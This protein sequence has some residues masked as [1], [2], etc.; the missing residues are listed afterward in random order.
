MKLTKILLCVAVVAAC[1]KAP[2]TGDT[3]DPTRATEA[4]DVDRSTPLPLDPDVRMGKLDNGLTYYIRRH[5]QPRQRAMLWLAVNAGS[6]LEDDDQKGLAHFVEHMAFNGTARFEK[7]TL[8]DFIEKTGMDF[9]ADLNAFTSFD[10]TVYMLTVPTDDQK[11]VTMGVDILED[12]AGAIAFDATEVDKER[13]VVIE[14]WRLG[15][16][17]QQRVF[18]KQW[19]IF[20]GG[21][22]YADRKPIGEKEILE[23]AP[24]DRLTSFYRDWYRPDLMAVIVVGDV[25]PS[26]MEKEIAA[27]FAKLEKPDRPREREN[28]P[29]PLLET[30][31]AAVVTDP[32]AQLATVTLAIKGPRTPVI[33]EADYR[34]KLI[35]DLFHGMLR[36]RLD[37]IRQRPDA[38]FAFAFSNTSDMGRAVDVFQLVAGAKPGRVDDALETLST[39]LERVRRHGFLAAEL[40]RQKADVLRRHQRAATEKD[41]VESRAYA[42]EIVRHFLGGEAM[43]GRDAELA[44]VERFLPTITLDE[45]DALAESWTE[46]KDRVV[47]ASGATRDKM[48]SEQELLAIVSSVAK[49]DVSPYVEESAG[50]T[51]MAELP[52]S[53]TIVDKKKLEPIGT[54]VW[55]LSNGAKVVVKPTDFKNDEVLF[56]AFS[57]GGHSLASKADY[58]S[59]SSAS[60][61][62][63][64][65]GV[66]PFDAATIRKLLA[67]KVANVQPWVGE[68]E[69]GLSGSASPR[70]LET[71]LQ[72]VHL[73]FTSPRRDPEAFEAWRSSTAAFVKNR[74]LN[75]Q[76]YFFEKL[77]AFVSN[78]HPRRLPMTMEALEEVELEKA[79]AFYQDRFADAGDFVFVFVG[80]VDEA[81]L[82]QLAARYL[83]SLPSTGRKEK[84]KDVGVKLPK[85]IKKLRVEKGQDPKSFVFITFH[86]DVKWT[87][88]A[89]DDLEILGEVLDI[90]LREVLREDMSGVYGAFSRGNLERRPKQRYTYSVGFGC[91]PENV[92][93]LQAAVFEIV[94]SVKITGVSETY[95]EKVREQR[96]RK[97]ETDQRTNAFWARALADH[98]RYGTDPNAILEREQQAIERVTSENVQTAARRYLS[99][100]HVDAVLMPESTAGG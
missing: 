48:P 64:Q 53:G 63:S 46:R 88:E 96:R 21:S 5:E 91:A 49:R 4:G 57:P 56:Q 61:I 19:P 18:D 99:N 35:E 38:P 16:G 25:D 45:V 74:D 31:R 15:R 30:T 37:E 28:V 47:L 86:G 11:V 9:G 97:L 10:E 65:S 6:V 94:A 3:A 54:S 27:R 23:N 81:A 52:A 75:P 41:K 60:A 100:Q 39:E 8:I 32:E 93:K 71:M 1:T 36:A 95:L 77:Q 17:A 66:G 44:L 58:R 73:Y 89:E 78:D 76:M 68:L 80:N 92:D 26:T 62:V 67:G 29:V 40:E 98:F 7:N 42:F 13:G 2:S 24:V 50:A 22:K 79:F 85:G 90:R 43:P 12:W 87:P 33:T 69:E 83:A 55:T 84:W 14:E 82:E 59:A 72:L 20:L 51:L 34:D 70:D